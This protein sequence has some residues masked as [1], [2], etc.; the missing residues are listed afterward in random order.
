[1]MSYKNQ[2]VFPSPALLIPSSVTWQC[3]LQCSGAS[4][5]WTAVRRQRP[6]PEVLAGTC[7]SPAGDGKNGSTENR[8]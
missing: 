4:T 1:M 6:D 8:G 2:L 7:A 5:A 3:S